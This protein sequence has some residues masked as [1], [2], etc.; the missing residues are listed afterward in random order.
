M[1]KLSRF[2]SFREFWP[3]YLSEHA[4][5]TSRFLHMTGTVTAA[6][7][8]ILLM[9]TGNLWFLLASLI[10]GYGFAWFGHF[11]I[12]H[13]RPMTF[14][15]PIWSLRGDLLMFYLACTG[16]LKNELKHYSLENQEKSH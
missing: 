6:I 3:H 8:L 12:E 14:T 10:A 13:N 15:H 11:S 2:Q 9:L 1:T 4:S 5:P 7:L 16:N